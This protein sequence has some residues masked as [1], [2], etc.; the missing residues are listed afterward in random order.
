MVNR[1]SVPSFFV[2][3]DNYRYTIC[4]R[5]A[6]EVAS[7]VIHRLVRCGLRVLATEAAHPL[8]VRRTVSFC[9]CINNETHEMQIEGVTAVLC[10]TVEDVQNAWSR[11]M[12]FPMVI[13]PELTLLFAL[14]MKTIRPNVIV[15]A[16]LR[17]KQSGRWL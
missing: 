16:T 5:G 1:H 12:C 8:A 6:G 15:D 11:P 4:V 7:G 13:D 3:M 10:G 9:E 14:L 2:F 17:K